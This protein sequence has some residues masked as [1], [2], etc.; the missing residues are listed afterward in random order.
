MRRARSFRVSYLDASIGQF[1]I[2]VSYE[3]YNSSSKLLF[4]ER[5]PVS[6]KYGD[7]RDMGLR[8]AKTFDYF[9]YSAG[10]FNGTTLDNL[11]NNKQK[12]PRCGS[13]H[14]RFQDC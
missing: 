9:G 7:V 13:R 10:L 2:P 11:D 4:A 14:I 5:A 3:G 6:R 1:K 12:M 8:L